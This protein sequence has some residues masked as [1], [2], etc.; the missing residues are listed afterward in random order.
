MNS[1]KLITISVSVILSILL[2]LFIIHFFTKRFKSKLN[3]DGRIKVSFGIWYAALFLTGTNIIS[4]VINTV[5]EVIDNL[6]KI[7]PANFSL[8]LVKSVSLIIGVG[9]IW[10][11]VWVFVTK[12]LIKVIK[13]KVDEHQEMEDDNFNYFIIKAVMLIG[14]IFSLSPLLSE[15][16]RTLI[17]SIELPFYH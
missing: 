4:V 10:F 17:P 14:L 8:Q 1:L 6:T 11:F 3:N 13:L 15:L 12:F 16:L 2:L 5:I 7:N 9:F